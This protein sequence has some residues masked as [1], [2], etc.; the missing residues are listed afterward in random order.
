MTSIGALASNVLPIN[1]SQTT[2]T[3]Q[4]QTIASRKTD[5]NLNSIFK[6]NSNNFLE[7]F[8]ETLKNFSSDTAII[9]YSSKSIAPDTASA[10]T[11]S[12]EKFLH[13]L[14]HSLTKGSNQV[15]ESDPSTPDDY[16]I[17]VNRTLFPE[18]TAFMPVQMA[19]NYSSTPAM[20][21]EDLIPTLDNNSNSSRELNN[22]FNNL[23]ESLA[24][25]STDSN[26]TNTSLNS[27][28]LQN[29]L[30]QL[31]TTM[32]NPNLLQSSVGNLFYAVA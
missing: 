22:D 32:N 19:Y 24:A 7:N 5:T 1:A 26:T 18:Q 16:D 9:D 23:V 21:L 27:V 11:T 20:L 29:F 17:D 10:T 31:A 30:K 13:D 2:N 8:L 3:V 15:S 25:S 4:L 14:Y 6:A 12:V 28:N